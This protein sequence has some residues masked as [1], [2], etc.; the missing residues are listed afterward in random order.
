M[1][2]T[3][4]CNPASP[5]SSET[6]LKEDFGFRQKLA[7]P[8]QYSLGLC[9][10]I[11]CCHTPTPTPAVPPQLFIIVISFDKCIVSEP[12]ELEQRW[13][14]I[15]PIIEVMSIVDKAP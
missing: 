15:S 14:L 5:I 10:L 11:K 1:S 12:A 13:G 9:S 8:S 2:P 6:P 3:S 7:T 4:L